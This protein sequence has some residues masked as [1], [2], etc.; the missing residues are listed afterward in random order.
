MSRIKIIRS[1]LSFTLICLIILACAR[2]RDSSSGISISYPF[3]NALFPAEFPAPT[4]EWTNKVKD[5]SSWEV[6]LTIRNK[7]FSIK[8]N[9]RQTKWTP[10]K[11]EWD[12]LKYLSN[13]GKIYFKV[14][15]SGDDNFSR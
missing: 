13:S 1:V 7:S 3:N 14:K 8:D 10:E 5:S 6:T 15:K 11:S 2:K 4:F 12:S 9:T